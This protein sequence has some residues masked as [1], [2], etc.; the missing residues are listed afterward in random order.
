MIRGAMSAPPDAD[1]DAVLAYAAH[2]KDCAYCKSANTPEQ[3]CP[4]GGVL[5]DE[6]CDDDPTEVG[7]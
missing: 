5:W 6:V 4:T 2:V 3:L 1:V 7:R